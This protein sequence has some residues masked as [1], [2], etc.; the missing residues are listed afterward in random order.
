[1]RGVNRRLILENFCVLCL[2]RMEKRL[3]WGV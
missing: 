1:M 2:F 3:G